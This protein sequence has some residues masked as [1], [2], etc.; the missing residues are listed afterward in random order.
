MISYDEVLT[1]AQQLS[2]AEKAQLIEDIGAA[3]RR[4][5]EVEAFQR[6]SWHEFIAQTA[7]SL[8][9]TPIERPPQPSYEDRESLE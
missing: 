8:A 9:E 4:D 3:L 7:G 1:V 2:L 5:L 6:M